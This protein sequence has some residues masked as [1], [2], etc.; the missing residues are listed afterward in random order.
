MALKC[1]EKQRQA[2]PSLVV[3]AVSCSLYV[4]AHWCEQI[5]IGEQPDQAEGKG[6]SPQ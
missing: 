4:K 5:R 2:E 6:L 3:T 1:P